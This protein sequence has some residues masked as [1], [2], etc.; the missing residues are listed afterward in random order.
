ME[1]IGVDA[2]LLVHARK[3]QPDD[4]NP[5]SDERDLPVYS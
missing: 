4:E 2:L 1:Y 3:Q 5:V